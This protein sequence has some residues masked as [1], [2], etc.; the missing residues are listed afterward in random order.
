MVEVCQSCR[1]G[2][3]QRNAITALCNLTRDGNDGVAR[4]LPCP[5][6]DR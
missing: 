4:A 5:T 1:D 6:C 2:K 3:V